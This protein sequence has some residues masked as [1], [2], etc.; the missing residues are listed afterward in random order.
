[1][2]LSRASPACGNCRTRRIKCNFLRPR[3]S[4]CARAGLECG[5]YRSRSDLLFRDQTKAI[6]R[7]VE[8]EGVDFLRPNNTT[9]CGSPLVKPTFHVDELAQKVF[10]DNFPVLGEGCRSWMESRAVQPSSSTISLTSVG[11]AALALIHKDPHMMDLARR[12]YHIAIKSLTA[13]IRH[14]GA[15]GVEQSIAACF[16]LSIFEV[17]TCDKS[18]VSDAWPKHIIGAATFLG[19]LCSANEIPR[20]PVSEVVDICFNTTLACLVSNTL[21]PSF[22]LELSNTPEPPDTLEDDQ[23]PLAL[24]MHLFAIIGRLVNVHNSVDP[25]MLTPGQT[26]NFVIH[27]TQALEDWAAS[28]PSSWKHEENKDRVHGSHANVWFARIWTYYRLGR[29][30][31]N[32][33]ILNH[34]DIFSSPDQCDR[35]CAISSDMSRDIFDTFPFLF[36]SERTSSA[37]I[38]LSTTLFFMTSVLQSLSMIA[39]RNIVFEEWSVPASKALGE[40]FTLARDIVAQNLRQK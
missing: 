21:V 30:L 8:R 17:L 40:R 19:C 35:L 13:A 12:K 31:A 26:I 5:G 1:M 32:R 36:E 39:D 3:C 7:K 34:L 10:A 37:S 20:S 33:I 28:L 14:H 29:I 11:L 15:P 4:Q 16:I 25:N 18:S 9:A 24:A 6:I 38:P 27:S 2:T 22:L 23:R